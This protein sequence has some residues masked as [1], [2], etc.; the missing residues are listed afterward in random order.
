MSRNL[1]RLVFV[2]A[3]LMAAAAPTLAQYDKDGRYVP[4]P[5]GIPSD[6]NASVIPGYSGAPGATANGTPAWPRGQIPTQPSV[7]LPRARSPSVTSSGLPPV[8]LTE[9]QCRQG[10][11][12]KSGLARRIFEKR[13]EARFGL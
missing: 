9:A 4:S 11:S 5:N 10:W 3:L 8:V 6:P 2:G 7:T 1:R 12:R 13:C